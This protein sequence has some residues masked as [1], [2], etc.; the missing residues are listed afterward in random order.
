M[1]EVK[2]ILDCIKLSGKQ[3]FV[4]VTISSI[5]LFSPTELITLIGL[6]KL[7]EITQPWVGGI[8][9]ISLSILVT[10]I[11]HP[12]YQFLT[13][14]VKDWLSLRRGHKRL[15]QL[16]PDEK[17]F[18]KHYIEH[19]TRT[20]S[21]SLA[22]GIVNELVTVGIVRRASNMGLYDNFFAYNI[23]PWAWNYLKKNRS[24]VEENE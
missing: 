16:T 1:L 17:A 24:L 10:E 8:W 12:T 15:E 7:K 6:T 3:A 4:L 22:D 20:N 2:K 5:L 23:Q 18:L 21:S 9:I 13:K 19:D 11:A 14:K